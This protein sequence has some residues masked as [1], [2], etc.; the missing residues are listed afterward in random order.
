MVELLLIGA[1][2]VG[3]K[4]QLL[5]LMHQGV[6]IRERLRRKNLAAS[7]RPDETVSTRESYWLDNFAWAFSSC[8][9]NSKV[10]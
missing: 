5:E 6:G 4:N 7:R 8:L 10:E 2:L 9:A 3:P 1:R